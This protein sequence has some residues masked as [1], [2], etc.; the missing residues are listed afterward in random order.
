MEITISLEFENLNVDE[1][2]LL[3]IRRAVKTIGKI[4][5]VESSE[6][7]I[8]LTNDEK[9]HILNKTYRGI[10]RPT[11]VLSFA[12]R[13]SDEPEIIYDNDEVNVKES[14]GDIII[15]VER[16]KIQADEYNHSLLRE[17]VFLT[18]HGMLHLLGYDHMKEEDRI[19]ME[20][21]QKFIMEQLGI[22]R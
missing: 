5:D 4:Y 17:I 15:S 9:I 1:N 14:L 3:E 8:T 7:S 21:E 18:V 22:K 13:E 2:I 20:N 16:A 19:E 6:V 11:D 12:F 10:D